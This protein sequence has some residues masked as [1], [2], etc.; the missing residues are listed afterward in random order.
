MYE[1]YEEDKYMSK[2]V[3]MQEDAEEE[4]FSVLEE[5]NFTH[6]WTKDSILELQ[7]TFSKDYERALDILRLESP[8]NCQSVFGMRSELLV[9]LQFDR[10]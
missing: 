9:V 2:L 1:H 5:V 3:K 8:T 10:V 7:C 4:V 6:L